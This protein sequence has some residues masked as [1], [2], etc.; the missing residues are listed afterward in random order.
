MS[1]TTSAYPAKRRYCG[2]VARRYEHSRLASPRRR[3]IWEREFQLV[4]RILKEHVRGHSAILDAPTGTGRFVS[5]FERLGHTVTGVDISIDMLKLHPLSAVAGPSLA[6]SDCE[7]LPFRDGIFDYVFSLRFLG[8]VPPSVRV[9]ILREFKRVSSQGIIV[10]FPVLNAFTKLKFDLG[11]LYCK[12]KNGRP[13]PWWPASS[14]SLPQEL[15]A[16]GL[17]VAHEMRLLG[18][19][20]QI[21]LLYLTSNDSCQF[22]AR[23][24]NQPIH[25]ASA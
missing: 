19:F 10:G 17:R 1:Q 3:L 25:L 13:W 21:A 12:L 9:R 22:T 15:D 11:N 16:A 24:A 7:F 14:R 6:R 8:Q 4:E 18:P 5:L 20:S 23:T 2:K